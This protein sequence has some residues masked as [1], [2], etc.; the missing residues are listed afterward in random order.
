M[1]TCTVIIIHLDGTNVCVPHFIAIHLILVK[2]VVELEE[3]VKGGPDMRS[4]P[5]M[6]KKVERLKL[7]RNSSPDFSVNQSGGQTSVEP[8]KVFWGI[9]CDVYGPVPA[10]ELLFS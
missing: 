8:N 1:L 3:K 9:Q 4:D 10:S 2:L 7:N 6:I 5:Q